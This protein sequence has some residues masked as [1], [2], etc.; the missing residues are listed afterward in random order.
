MKNKFILMLIVTFLAFA[1]NTDSIITEEQEFNEAQEIN[2]ELTT[3]VDITNIESD[4]SNI[5]LNLD[6][7][8]PSQINI[9]QASLFGGDFPYTAFD[10]LECGNWN[11][12]L[13][14]SSTDPQ[15]F[16]FRV[17]NITYNFVFS[18]DGPTQNEINCIRKE[19]FDHNP[20]LQLLID[21]D[22]N[23]F[24]E[25][26]VDTDAPTIPILFNFSNGTDGVTTKAKASTDPRASA[27]E[28]P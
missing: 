11:P 19:Y 21:N 6:P 26:W 17:L 3:D 22:G 9:P 20:N 23:R 5:N 12:A 1:C 25:T 14:L 7:L 8:N 28:R 27:T 15:A 18:P 24:T 2:L 13:Y 10:D 16:G 4:T